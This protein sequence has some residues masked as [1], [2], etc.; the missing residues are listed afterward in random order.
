M[1]YKGRKFEVSIIEFPIFLLK[2]NSG[3]YI[4]PEDVMEMRTI[5]SKI[6]DGSKFTVLLDATNTFQVDPKARA[7]IAGKEFSE[8]RIGAAFVVTSLASRLIGNFFIRFNRPASPTKLFSNQQ[9]ALEWL[10]KLLKKQA[11]DHKE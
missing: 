2:V 11:V 7:I 3:E 9:D 10:R 6:A 4:E 1:T 5:F 8:Q